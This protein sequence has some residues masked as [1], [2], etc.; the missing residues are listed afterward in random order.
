M[1]IWESYFIGDVFSVSQSIA[2]VCCHW[3]T[4]ESQA[5]VYIRIIHNHI[6]HWNPV[7]FHVK[8]RSTPLQTQCC[9][10]ER[11]SSCT[12]HP[13]AVMNWWIRSNFC[14][15]WWCVYVYHSV[16]NVQN[17]HSLTL[18]IEKHYLWLSN[19]SQLLLFMDNRQLISF[20]P[21]I[22]HPL[23]ATTFWILL[24]KWPN[25]TIL[26]NLLKM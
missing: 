2:F 21:Y 17:Y 15:S 14:S 3:D 1:M 8:D 6:H 26:K 11:K 12:S 19:R 18:M 22:V 10:F 7:H 16:V 9:T 13:F 23:F 4:Y 25:F 20:W 5:H 24:L